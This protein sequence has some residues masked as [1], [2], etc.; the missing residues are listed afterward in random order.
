MI[1]YPRSERM[2][3]KSMEITGKSL[4]LSH[5]KIDE[6]QST[7]QW[8]INGKSMDN[9]K[10]MDSSIENQSNKNGNSIDN[11]WNING[12]PMDK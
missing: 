9:R 11:K 1:L 7:H 12:K 8:K 6:T 4:K 3:G 10:L 5:W 2:A